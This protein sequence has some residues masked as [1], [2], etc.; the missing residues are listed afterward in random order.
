MKR[1]IAILMIF[2]VI[3][4][5]SACKKDKTKEEP[6]VPEIES[7]TEKESE[8]TTKE[9]L[10]YDET[11]WYELQDGVLI[12]CLEA[13]AT[14]GYTWSY[15]IDNESILE[16]QGA[17]YL[18]NDHPDGMVGVGGFYKG[19]FA[20]VSDGKATVSFAYARSWEEDEP[21]CRTCDITVQVENGRIVEIT[22]YTDI[23]VRSSIY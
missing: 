15:S 11:T 19:T 23:T 3:L 5:L 21:P 12:V 9:N 18:E 10:S 16:C 17:K 7:T 14:T 4:S 1:F 8:S 2:T 22:N 20:G 13:N 6:T